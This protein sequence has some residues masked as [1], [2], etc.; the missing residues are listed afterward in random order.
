MHRVKE[1]RFDEYCK[2]CV[3]YEKKESEDPCWDC[4]NHAWNYDTHAPVD[5]KEK[6]NSQQKQSP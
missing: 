4:L 3:H 6:D 5:F 1:V 2:K